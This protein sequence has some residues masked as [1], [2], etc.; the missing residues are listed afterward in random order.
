[1]NQTSRQRPCRTSPTAS[2]PTSGV[3]WVWPWIELGIPMGARVAMVSHN[4]ARLLT[5]FYGVSGNGR[6]FVPINFRLSRDE[7]AYIVEHCGAVALLIDPELADD[8]GDVPCE[9]VWIM[10]DECDAVWY[11][12]AGEPAA[13]EPDEDATASINYTSGHHRTAQGCRA[14]PPGPVDQRRHLRVARRRVTDRDVYLHTLPMFH[15]DGWG[16]LYTVSA[17]GVKHIVLRKVD[18]RRDPAAGRGT[19]RHADVWRAGGR[20][21]GARRSQGLGRRDPR[22]GQGADGRR[23]SPA[24]DVGHRGDGDRARLGVHPDLRPDR[25]RSAAHD[26]SFAG[27]SGTTCRPQNGPPSWV[28][29]VLPTIG[30]KMGVSKDGELL[31][32][33][34]PHPEVV[35][36]ES[37]RPAPRRWTAVGSTPAMAGC[38][39]DEGYYT[40][41]DR[42]KD[43]IISGGENVSSIEVEDV[44]FSHPA[45]NEVAII[46]VPAREVG[47]NRQGPGRPRAGFG[48]RASVS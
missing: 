37:R 36:G 40:I 30:I 19:R 28:E 18:G 7:V 12:R 21:G 3:R 15:C 41:T 11:G 4:S 31:A 25:D 32:Q 2:W 24:A 22:A 1:M 33:R 45:V 42:K 6:V 23:R 20:D 27:P 14:D 43:V 44:L 29:P 17:M 39:D 9:R 5:S 46:G 48:R 26:V 35:L 34:Q 13:W 38:I 16:M 10:G 8:L 47:R